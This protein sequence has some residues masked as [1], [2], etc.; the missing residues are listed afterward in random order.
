MLSGFAPFFD[1]CPG[2][3][4]QVS[5]ALLDHRRMNHDFPF[6]R[7]AKERKQQEKAASAVAK[8]VAQPPDLAAENAQLR[9]RLMAMQVERDFWSE[10]ARTFQNH[11]QTV[12]RSQASILEQMSRSAVCEGEVHAA[13]ADMSTQLRQPLTTVEATMALAA[14]ARDSTQGN[15]TA[16]NAGQAAKRVERQ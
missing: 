13:I 4:F 12:L 11:L 15:Y 7:T 9:T 8:P 6:V 16:V 10:Q 3:G 1:A 2:M 5:C 14:A